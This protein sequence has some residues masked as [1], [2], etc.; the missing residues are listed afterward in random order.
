[1]RIQSKNELSVIFVVKNAMIDPRK[2]K[3]NSHG[4]DL[5][6]SLKK[7]ALRRALKDSWNTDYQKFRVGEGIT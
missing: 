5:E 2:K 4:K 3:I 7:Y 1:M 6:C